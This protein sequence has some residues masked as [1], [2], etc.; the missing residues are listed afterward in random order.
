MSVILVSTW[1]EKK[2]ARIKETWK[3]NSVRT[4]EANLSVVSE[5]F[6]KKGLKI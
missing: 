5:M 4:Y 3:E 6:M 1:F 2:Y